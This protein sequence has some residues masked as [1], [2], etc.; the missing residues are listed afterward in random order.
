MGGLLNHYTCTYLALC[1][2]LVQ[3]VA[4]SSS[5][6]KKS[7]IICST[8][9]YVHIV[10][11]KAVLKK[12]HFSVNSILV[13][14]FVNKL[15]RKIPQKIWGTCRDCS[16]LHQIRSWHKDTACSPQLHQPST[17]ARCKKTNT[18]K[19]HP[20]PLPQLTPSPQPQPPPY[21]QFIL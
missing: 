18:I 10:I 8:Y 3:L 16:S 7:I 4:L 6:W 2:F 19:P 5:S 14:C 17:A 13:Y 21:Q 12:P 15:S 1:L 9:S 11:F 20:L